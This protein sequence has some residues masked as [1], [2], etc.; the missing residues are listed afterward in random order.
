MG[1]TVVTGRGNAGKTGRLYRSVRE[2]AEK[3]SSPVVLLPSSPDVQRARREF[4]AEGVRGVRVAVLDRWIVEIWG[5]W[6]DGRALVVTGQREALM[7]EAI[8]EHELHALADS[9]RHSGFVDS[10]ASLA[11]RIADPAML[12]TGT[13]HDSEIRSI[14]VAY[15]DLCLERGLAEQV[16]A[17]GH[18]ATSPPEELPPLYVN[19]FTDL[20]PGQER[21]LVSASQATPVWVALPWEA[22][23]AATEA[24]EALVGRLAAVGTHVHE[25]A[26]EI[27]DELGALERA[28]FTTDGRLEAAGMVLMGEVPDEVREVTAA[29]D[30]VR[31]SIDKG[32]EPSRIA[33]TFRAAGRRAESVAAAAHEA[34]VP[35]YADVRVPLA[36]SSLGRALFALLDVTSGRDVSRQRWSAYVQS[37]YSG[38]TPG[39][40]AGLDLRWRRD[41]AGGEDLAGGVEALGGGALR[42]VAA[43][44]AVCTGGSGPTL[45]KWKE[46]V[47]SLA[48][49]AW[50]VR[51]RDH[52]QGAEDAAAHAGVLGTLTALSAVCDELREPDVRKA[53]ERADITVSSGDESSCVHFTEARRVRATRYD[54]V[55]LGGLNSEEFSSER[56]PSWESA[57]LE[58]VG[59]GTEDA[60]RLHERLLFYSLVTRARTG[61][62]LLRSTGEGEG[63]AKRPSVFWEEVADLYRERGQAAGPLPPQMT[64]ITN[65]RAKPVGT[66]IA[67]TP[68]RR[69]ARATCG[70]PYRPVRGGSLGGLALERLSATE[71]F[72]VTEIEMYLSCPYRWF[73]H[74]ALRPKEIDRELGVREWGSAAHEIL[75]RFYEVLPERTGQRRVLPETRAAAH[76]LLEEVAEGILSKWRGAAIGLTEECGLAQ[77]RT[78]VHQVIEDDADYLDGFEPCAGELRFGR[79]QDKPFEFGGARLSGSI[80]RVDCSGNSLVVTDY[81]WGLSIT[82]HGG[83]AKEG[84]VQLPVYAAAAGGLLEGQAVGAVYRT[85]AARRAVRGF[86]RDDAVELCGWGTRTDPVDAKGFEQVIEDAAERVAGAVEGIRRGSIEARSSEGACRYCGAAPVCAA[87]GTR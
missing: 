60:E 56:D 50:A 19:R 2:E 72:S 27:A 1:L 85:L 44:K 81:K 51:D 17:V 12:E 82:G 64:F 78:R 22:G 54:L 71:E 43:A 47:D 87:G 39:R 45:A 26:P 65:E 14:L 34:G 20:S 62:V 52:P 63:R 41:R 57:F 40:A 32:T 77:V 15:R 23:H 35:L 59:Q 84:L 6:G 66:A 37:I 36:R 86:W 80:D 25:P 70:S 31:R 69:A 29:I 30:A 10:L 33:L 53:L 58:R 7:A 13:P 18:L 68:G 74:R 42:A 73:F 79:A 24:L 9:A 5:L 16:E 55:V 28:L 38:I 46:L 4:A 76:E 8:V 67:R 61:L 75:G 21:F 11:R 49:N 83:F 48:A 3:G